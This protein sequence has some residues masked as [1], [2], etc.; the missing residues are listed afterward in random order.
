MIRVVWS[1]GVTERFDDRPTAEAAIATVL[2]T[3][4]YDWTRDAVYSCEED[5]DADLD[6]SRPKARIVETYD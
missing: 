3:P 4:V 5:A 1:H 2:S 6:G